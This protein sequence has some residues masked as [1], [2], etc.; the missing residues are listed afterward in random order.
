MVKEKKYTWKDNFKKPE[1]E[2]KL[3]EPQKR[4][5][6]CR[7]CDSGRFTL[8]IENHIMCRRCRACGDV[9]EV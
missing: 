2:D 6:I 9:I 1:K 7:E 8:F 4:A 3:S 5:G